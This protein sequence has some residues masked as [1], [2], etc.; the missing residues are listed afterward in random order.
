[1]TPISARSLR[2]T[3]QGASA[4]EPSGKVVFLYDLDALEQA[5]R[6]VLGE[7]RRLAALNDVLRPAHGVRRVDREDLADANPQNCYVRK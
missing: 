4:S 3:S 6:L 1:M 5:P 2:P 7:D